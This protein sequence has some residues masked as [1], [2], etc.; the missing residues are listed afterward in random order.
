MYLYHTQTKQRT[1]FLSIVKG[2]PC[3][4]AFQLRRP[5]QEALADELRLSEEKISLEPDQSMAGA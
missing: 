4:A 1:Q 3:A 2:E 5:N